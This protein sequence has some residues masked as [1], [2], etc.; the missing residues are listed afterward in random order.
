MR[1]HSNLTVTDI[2][3]TCVSNDET[4]AKEIYDYLFSK[5]EKQKQFEDGKN[6]RITT[7]LIKFVAQDS[8]IRI[9]HDTLVPMGMIKWTLESFLKSDPVRFK[10]HDVIEFGDTFTIGKLL[11]PSKAELL[12]CEICG[13]FT[14]Y[15]EE[16]HTHRMTHYGL[17]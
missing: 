4:F 8:E 11:D 3:I 13:F 6:L 17:G 15:A 12:A 10:D 5:L 7:E 16:L 14:P 9:H 2:V 1:I